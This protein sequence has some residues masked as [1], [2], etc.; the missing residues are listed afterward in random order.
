MFFFSFSHKVPPTSI[1][2]KTSSNLMLVICL[3]RLPC[4]ATTYVYLFNLVIQFC[5]LFYMIVLPADFIFLY[6]IYMIVYMYQPGIFFFDCSFS[7]CWQKR[8]YECKLC[9]CTGGS[10]LCVRAHPLLGGVWRARQEWGGT[11]NCD[12]TMIMWMCTPTTSSH[13]EARPSVYWA[14]PLY[15]WTSPSSTNWIP[16]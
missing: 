12:T 8:G 9:T 13:H 16:L 14:L 10:V 3:H 2:N 6:C 5:A 11:S 4:C 7:L 15:W 1:A